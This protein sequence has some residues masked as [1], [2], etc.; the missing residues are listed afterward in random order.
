MTIQMA[1]LK[2]VLCPW[3][4]LW[5][6]AEVWDLENSATLDRLFESLVIARRRTER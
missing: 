5:V 1:S 4:F 6:L 2:L 3:S